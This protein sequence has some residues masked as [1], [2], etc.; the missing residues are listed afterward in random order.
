MAV[1]E[2]ITSFVEAF[3]ALAG[4]AALT[5][6]SQELADEINGMILSEECLIDSPL[7]ADFLVGDQYTFMPA[8]NPWQTIPVPLDKE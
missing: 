3:L 8:L 5:P 1:R 7:K 4:Q 2:G 6:I